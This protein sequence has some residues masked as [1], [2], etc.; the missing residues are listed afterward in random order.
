M[1]CI[2]CSRNFDYFLCT[3]DIKEVEKYIKP[4][5]CSLIEK[6]KKDQHPYYFVSSLETFEKELVDQKVMKENPYQSSTLQF[7]RLIG[8]EPVSDCY[9]VIKSD[10]S[11][12]YIVPYHIFYTTNVID[13]DSHMFGY[14]DHFVFHS[15]TELAKHNKAYRREN[16]NPFSHTKEYKDRIKK[17]YKD[18]IETNHVDDGMWIFSQLYV[19]YQSMDIEFDE[20]ECFVTKY[21]K[22]NLVPEWYWEMD[23]LHLRNDK[24]LIIPEMKKEKNRTY[25]EEIEWIKRFNPSGMLDNLVSVLLIEHYLDDIILYDTFKRITNDAYTF[26]DSLLEKDKKRYLWNQLVNMK[27]D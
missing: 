21:Q 17:F 8:K 5:L 10:L 24:S 26:L 16:Y 15:L 22:Q 27:T 9:F 7:G 18:Y 4:M 6:H 20:L 25:E 3:A 14:C 2:A 12:L 19:Y 1:E 23:Q 13:G 11:E